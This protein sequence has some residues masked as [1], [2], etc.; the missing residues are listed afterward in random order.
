MAKM[1]RIRSFFS[2]SMEADCEYCSHSFKKDGETRCGARRTLGET[3]CRKFQYDP[4]K[5]TPRN[6]PPLREYD[7]EDFKL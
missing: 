6:L 4:L 2:P 1:K 3:G 7:P 5:R